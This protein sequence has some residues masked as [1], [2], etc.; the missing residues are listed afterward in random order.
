VL[1]APVGVI[2]TGAP[3]K[4]GAPTATE[5]EG[6]GEVVSDGGVEEHVVVESSDSDE[7]VRAQGKAAGAKKARKYVTDKD[8]AEHLEQ[9]KKT[10]RKNQAAGTYEQDDEEA[11]QKSAVKSTE[12]EKRDAV[13]VLLG[14]KFELDAVAKERKEKREA[15]AQEAREK[16]EH[17]RDLA[18]DKQAAEDR[19]S[20]QQF[21]AGLMGIMSKVSDG[22]VQGLGTLQKP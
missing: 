22:L 9:D 1:V 8:V 21:M 5:Q 14:K 3:P 6:N 7:D 2:D 15:E 4:Q 11:G 16:R 17:E 10:L 20:N 12:K 19:N 13:M 18:R